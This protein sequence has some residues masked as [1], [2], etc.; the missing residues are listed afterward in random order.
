MTQPT[1]TVSPPQIGTQPDDG[2]LPPFVG[3]AL[4]V[5]AGSALWAGF[6]A[7]VT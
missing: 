5:V 4:A 7:L 2:N 3:V 1:D 6:F